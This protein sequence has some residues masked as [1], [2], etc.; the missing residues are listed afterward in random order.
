M[1]RLMEKTAHRSK[2]QATVG[3]GYGKE[4]QLPLSVWFG[5]KMQALLYSE[6]GVNQSIP[7]LWDKNKLKSNLSYNVLQGRQ[8]NRLPSKKFAVHNFPWFS[9]IVLVINFRTRESGELLSTSITGTRISLLE[10][11][12]RNLASAFYKI[13]YSYEPLLPSRVG[14]VRSRSKRGW[15]TGLTSFGWKGCRGNL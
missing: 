1:S 7:I 4:L 12:T 9:Q 10:S 15:Q 8:R 5:K 3:I 14:G 13:F 11:H 2:Y 6:S